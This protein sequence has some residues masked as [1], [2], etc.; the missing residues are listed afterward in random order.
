MKRILVVDDA[1]FMRTI[2][3]DIL[4]K[5]GFEVIAEASNGIEAIEQFKRHQPDIVTMD[6]TMPEMDGI[7]AL[8]ELIKIDQQAKVCMVSAMGQEQIIMESIKSGAK[9]FIVKPFNAESV[10]HKMSKL[11]A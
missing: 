5:N 1:V 3:K 6:I 7:L 2:L 10:V 4:V 8:K 9:D 11:S